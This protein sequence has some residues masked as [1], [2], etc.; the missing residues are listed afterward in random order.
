MKVAEMR[1]TS[2]PLAVR[3]KKSSFTWRASAS[4][5]RQQVPAAFG[6]FGNK[7]RL[8]NLPRRAPEPPGD[9]GPLAERGRE[10]SMRA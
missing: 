4:V 6:T 10:L 9:S 3:V 8:L 1:V 7:S 2:P 5:P